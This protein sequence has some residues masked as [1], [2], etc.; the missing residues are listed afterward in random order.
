MREAIVAVFN[1]TAEL[2]NTVADPIQLGLAFKTVAREFFSWVRPIER[3]PLD[4]YNDNNIMVG[5]SDPLDA[6]LGLGSV[7]GVEVVEVHVRDE[8]VILFTTPLDYN[9]Y[10]MDNN[11]LGDFIHCCRVFLDMVELDNMEMLAG[12]GVDNTTTAIELQV[13]RDYLLARYPIALTSTIG[14]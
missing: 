6:I 10:T 7:S 2:S 8:E 13:M 12:I 5:W 14:G 3:I 11:Y 4:T 1:D 9:T